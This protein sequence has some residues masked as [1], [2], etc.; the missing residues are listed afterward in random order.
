MRLTSDVTYR[1]TYRTDLVQIK[2]SCRCGFII[3]NKGNLMSA[4]NSFIQ[5]L[6]SYFLTVYKKLTYQRDITFLKKMNH[7][8]CNWLFMGCVA[9]SQNWPVMYTNK[10]QIS[11]PWGMPEKVCRT[12]H[13][14]Q[15][16]KQILSRT[17]CHRAKR[18]HYVSCVFYA[19]PFSRL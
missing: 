16:Y 14:D 7:K 8:D 2:N 19:K 1:S 6:D 3:Q 9:K 11:Q 5:S 15:I 18:D 13:L 12:M 10:Y 4:L 17:T